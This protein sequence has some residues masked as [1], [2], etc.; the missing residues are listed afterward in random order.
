MESG[1]PRSVALVTGVLAA[2]ALVCVLAGF[3]AT[4]LSA[5]CGSSGQSDGTYAVVGL[6]VGGLLA[7]AAAGMGVPFLP[8]W[9]ILACAAAFPITCAVAA[10]GSA[11]LAGLLPFAIAG[12]GAFWWFLRRP[13]VETWLRS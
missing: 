12:W 5:C 4:D 8:W 13:D 2:L 6:L 1:R 7:L 9:A 10:P 3:V 11:D